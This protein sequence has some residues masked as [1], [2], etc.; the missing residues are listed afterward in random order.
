MKIRNIASS[1]FSRKEKKELNKR[2]LKYGSLATGLTVMFVAAVVLV[3]IVATMLFERFPISL[4][5]TGNSIYSVSEETKDYVSGLEVSIDI[6]V[7]STEDSYR[8]VSD[9]A[10]QCAELLKLYTQYNPRIT[11]RYRDLLSNPDLVA[12]YVNLTIAE[13]DIIVEP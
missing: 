13:G 12:N 4:D 11:V 2:H 1:G 10:V 8:G 5:L 3:N 7:M 6:T 9:Y